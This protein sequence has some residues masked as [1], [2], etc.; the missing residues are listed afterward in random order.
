MT[1]SVTNPRWR[2]ISPQALLWWSGVPIHTLRRRE[3]DQP[4]RAIRAIRWPTPS[5][6]SVD[7]GGK[8]P[9]NDA[10]IAER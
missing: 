10:N 4:I 5:E 3:H 8:V 6:V 7:E 2:S 1:P 9:T